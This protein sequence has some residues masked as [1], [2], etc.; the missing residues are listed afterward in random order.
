MKLEMFL[1][2]IY[3]PFPFRM[4]NEIVSV[5]DHRLFIYL[6]NSVDPYQTAPSAPFCL[7]L[8]LKWDPIPNAKKYIF[9]NGAWKFLIE[10]F[11]KNCHCRKGQKPETLQHFFMSNARLSRKWKWDNWIR[12]FWVWTSLEYMNI[13]ER[14]NFPQFSKFTHYFPKILKR[15][16]G[17]HALEDT[18]YWKL[19]SLV[20]SISNGLWGFDFGH[21]IKVTIRSCMIE[22]NLSNWSKTTRSLEEDTV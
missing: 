7:N 14:C 9:S 18:S 21:I 11:G 4:W 8:G 5:P 13:H 3:V 16:T 10:K 12:F 6:A 1:L 20:N 2:I 22:N 15:N 17:I 19:G